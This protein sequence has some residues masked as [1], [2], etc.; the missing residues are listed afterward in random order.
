MND[1]K[2]TLDPEYVKWVGNHARAMLDLLYGAKPGL[3]PFDI[4]CFVHRLL[5]KFGKVAPIWSFKD[6]QG[7]RR[8][9]TDDQACEVIEDVGRKHD[10]EHG[11]N[12]TTLQAV[13]D[14]LFPEP[15]DPS[16]TT[17]P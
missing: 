7:I 2:N 1:T 17:S 4:D 3:E 5:A 6:V 8:Y 11:I 14:D 15:D 10:A 9:L 12:W 16:Q 13:A